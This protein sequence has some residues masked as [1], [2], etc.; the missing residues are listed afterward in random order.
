MNL[1]NKLTIARVI[2]IPFFVL[3]MLTGLGGAAPLPHPRPLE[4]GAKGGQSASPVKAPK[5]SAKVSFTSKG[6]A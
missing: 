5:A 4:P 6:A 3:F 1:P 2:M